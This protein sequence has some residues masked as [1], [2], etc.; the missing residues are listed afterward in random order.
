MQQSPAAPSSSDE[1]FD[2]GVMPAQARPPISPRVREWVRSGDRLATLIILFLVAASPLAIGTVHPQTRAIAFSL[3]GLVLLLVLTGRWL[4]HKRVVIPVFAWLLGT[5]CVGAL[6]QLLPLPAGLLKALS[7]AGDNI[8]Q[9]AADTQNYPARPLSLDT[10][11][12][13]S[14]LSKLGAYLAFFL[15]VTIHVRRPTRSAWLLRALVVT[16]LGVAVIGVLQAVF[17]TDRILFFYRPVRGFGTWVRGTFVNPNHFGALMCVAAPVALNLVF[18]ARS[19]RS[20]ALWL[21]ACLL[22]NI[23]TVTSLSRAAIGALALAEIGLGVTFLVVRGRN[24]VS[25]GKTLGAIAFLV[26]GLL[27]SILVTQERIDALDFSFSAEREDPQS[28]QFAWR[29]SIPLI[30]DFAWTGTGRGAFEAAFGRYNSEGGKVTY[31]WIENT[32]LQIVIDF[33]LPVATL[34]F[35]LFV[36]SLWSALK[37]V[38]RQPELLGALG[39]LVAWSLHDLADFSFEIPGVMLPALALAGVLFAATRQGKSSFTVSPRRI[40][41]LWPAAVLPLAL[42]VPVLQQEK[43]DT[44]LTAMMRSKDSPEQLEKRAR[45]LLALHPA[46]YAIPLVTGEQLVNV[47]HP[48]AMSWINHAMYLSPNHSRPHL[49]AGLYL[50]RIQRRRQSLLEFRAAAA[51]NSTPHLE[52]WPLALELF[53]NIDDLRYIVGDDVALANSFSKFLG[54][55][56]Q[57]T[58]ARGLTQHAL[59]VSPNNIR[60]MQDYLYHELGN[61]LAPEGMGVLKKLL[62]LDQT[63]RTLELAARSHVASGSPLDAASLLERIQA[64]N[65]NLLE[66]RC[67]TAMA[68]ARAGNTDRARR[69]MGLTQAWVLSPALRARTHDVLSQIETIEGN[70]HRAAWEAERRDELRG[71]RP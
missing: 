33:G 14:E 70:T 67:D 58:L 24:S 37:V 10:P 65:E 36:L 21:T 38:R 55:H 44:E 27:V 63:D 11:A 49:L 46:D 51:N 28:K 3:C 61:K 41:W 22:L 54:N 66:L 42:V 30:R 17:D 68:L 15:A 62:S 64:R 26:T 57:R 43:V 6:V 18:Q 56:N 50:A 39:G 9:L 59:S 16:A 31:P 12:T 19:R 25:I 48:R 34:A 13:V 40:T 47:V 1:S 69:L 45:A 23:A 4:R 8:F 20:T 71:K 7:P 32:P 5:L 52:I 60:A 29:N 2:S 35:V 53:P